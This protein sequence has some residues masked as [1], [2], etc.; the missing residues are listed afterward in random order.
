MTHFEALDTHE[1]YHS[2]EKFW[3]AVFNV[4]SD[5]KKIGKS[6]ILTEMRI[7]K[8]KIFLWVIG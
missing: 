5:A 2:L 6:D 1:C 7:C 3:A 8:N 4:K